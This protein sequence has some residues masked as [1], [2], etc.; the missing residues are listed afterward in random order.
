VNPAE[1]SLSDALARAGALVIT[2]DGE[3]TAFF[4]VQVEGSY[5]EYP[6]DRNDLAAS[7]EAFLTL[8]RRKGILR[9]REV[10]Q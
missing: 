9:D 5:E 10:D 1:Q 2:F 3:D 8:L 4:S 6:L 7:I